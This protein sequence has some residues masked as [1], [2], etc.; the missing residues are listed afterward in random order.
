MQ[1]FMPYEI[2]VS[3]SFPTKNTKRNVNDVRPVYEQ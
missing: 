3:I 2:I 1:P